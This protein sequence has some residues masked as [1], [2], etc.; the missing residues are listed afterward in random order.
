MQCFPVDFSIVSKEAEVIST[1]IIYYFLDS[2]D[3]NVK[4][5]KTF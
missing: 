5:F 1:A 3:H 2:F 4:R